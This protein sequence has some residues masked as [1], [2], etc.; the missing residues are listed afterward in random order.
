MRFILIVELCCE[1][2]KSMLGVVEV[3]ES[4]WL[5]GLFPAS[6]GL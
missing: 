2:S 3:T 1:L 6:L 4:V 5:C